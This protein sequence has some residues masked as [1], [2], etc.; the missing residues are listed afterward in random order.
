MKRQLLAWE[1]N[2]LARRGF[3][4]S[5]LDEHGEMPVEYIVGKAE[6]LGLELEL[7]QEVLI[8]RVETEELV[9]LVAKW[10]RESCL[11][12][13]EVGTGSGAVSVWLAKNFPAGKFF[14]SDISKA[15]LELARRNSAAQQVTNLQFFQSD[16]LT[17]L[18]ADFYPDVIVANLPYIPSSRLPSLPTSVRD[19]EPHL[20][21]FGGADGFAIIDRL[22]TQ[23][24]N[25]ATDSVTQKISSHQLPRAIFLE[26]DDSHT[27]DFF[28]RPNKNYSQPFSWQILPDTAGKNRFVIGLKIS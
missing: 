28:Q 21:L 10:L 14:A 6:F 15:A 1:H 3:D 18:P 25:R 5:R 24:V 7:S 20:A 26:I 23:I 13:L 9:G 22:L 16:L 27:L 11:S 12:V 2:F 4:F 17:N 19:F 8:P